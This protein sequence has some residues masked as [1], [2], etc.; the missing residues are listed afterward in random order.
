MI[1]VNDIFEIIYGINL[2]Y[3]N[4]EIEPDKNGIPFV[5]RTLQNNGVFGR[6]ARIEEIAPNPKNTISVAVS[7]SVMASFLQEEEYYS[8]RDVY[9]LTPKIK[10]SRNQLLYYCMVLK[11]N[12]YR[13]NYGRQANKTLKN[14][15]IPSIDEIP[16]WVNETKIPQKPT[17]E[18]INKNNIFLNKSEWK[19]FTL[20]ELFDISS[21]KDPIADKF[22]YGDIPY[23]S[24]TFTDNGISKWVNAEPIHNANTITVARNGSVG[25][26]FYQ[27]IPYCA[28]PD[29]I[30]IFK[31]KF[32]LNQFIAMFMITI[33]EGEKYRFNY[34]RKW[35]TSRMKSSKVM[36]PIDATGKP[37]WQFMENYIK[38]L[39]YSK[40]LLIQLI[41]SDLETT[42][43]PHTKTRKNLSQ[44]IIC[45]KPPC[46]FIE[47]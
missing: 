19:W 26:A 20:G 13:Y 33:I 25:S 36:L 27:P 34:G 21:S 12:K 11:A 28:S 47:R 23:I 9:F 2:E 39:P 46:N 17:K 38:S 35:G 29:D 43:L 40:N 41:R 10:L 45:S 3:Y 37:D 5:S 15:L 7:G 22:D 18:A 42:L 32:K 31:P 24:S 44:Q 8:G 6:V 1:K 4:M 14:I 30:R 16:S